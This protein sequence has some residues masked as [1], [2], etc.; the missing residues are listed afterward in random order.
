MKIALSWLKDHINFTES[1]EEI[2]T[3]LT[4][5]GLEVE[6]L[7]EV[8][9]IQGGL[10][11]VVVGEVKTCKPHPDADKL[12]I[13]TVDV[14]TGELLPIVCGAPNVA[15]GQKVVVATVGTTLYPSPDEPFKIKKAKIRGVESLGMLCAEDELG[16][17]QSHQGIMTLDAKTKI[18]TSA[19]ELFKLQS[20]QIIEIGLTPNRADATSHYG[21]A[22]EIQALTG[23]KLKEIQGAGVLVDGNC[24]IVIG[25]A[26]TQACP[27]YAGALIQ[28]VQIKESPEWLKTKLKSIGIAPKNNAVDLTNYILHD[29]GQPIHAFDADQIKG[30]KIIVGNL[31]DGT[32]FTTLDEKERELKPEDLMICDGNSR[33]LCLGGVLGGLNSGVSKN[34]TSIFL[35]SAYFSAD[36]VRKSSLV[37]GIKTDASFRFERGTDPESVLPALQKAIKLLC[38]LTGGEVV[39]GITD[40]YPQ[41]IPNFKFDVSISQIQGL[42]G[43]EIPE[44]RIKEILSSLE[45][46]IEDQS[47][48]SLSLVVPS[49]RVDVQRQADVAEE[50]LRIFGFENVPIDKNLSSKFLASNNNQNEIVTDKIAEV[51]IGNGFYESITNSL[52]KPQYTEFIEGLEESQNVQILNKL[53]EDLG[54]MRQ[55]LLFSGLEVI[56][57]NIN[58]QH[59][60]A[61]LF[62]FGKTYHLR[63]G[64]YV[65]HKVLG[66]WVT[67]NTN[68]ESWYKKTT[69]SD[70]L[71]IATPIS[72]FFERLGIKVTKQEKTAHQQFSSGIDLKARNQVIGSAG[73]VKQA[74]L[75]KAGIN[76][77]VFYAEFDFEALAAFGTDQLK[78]ETLSKYPEVRRDLSVVL[79]LSA[80]FEEVQAVARKTEKKLLKKVNVFD[81][82]RGEKLEQ[83][84]KSYSV[85]FV[86]QDKEN[87]L[88]DKVIDQV[89]NKLIQNFERELGAVIRR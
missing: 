58:R 55:S 47:G 72:L 22:R 76:Q 25:I 59:E 41:K 19:A 9:S 36:A 81:T 48:D 75:E 46:K 44:S 24:P 79:D 35:E 7:E 1:P 33:P 74:L 71:S 60:N 6:G 34:T 40:I 89:M 38:E 31:A 57:H 53:S 82:Y 86:L 56:K 12:K 83:G 85:S 62:E 87:T 51:L 52:S 69:P 13:T 5:S 20:E 88:T 16:L 26:N 77:P 39:G 30:E 8:E 80:T 2:C 68:S 43:V 10:K 54:I 23:H 45:I 32:K 42:I 84:K 78:V 61:K 50:V 14:G 18:G 67:G 70:F 63:E 4:A 29:L 3:K 66:L 15:A 28:N 73:Q 27:R 17:G 64:S 49:Y 65:E 37:H 21:V 11:G